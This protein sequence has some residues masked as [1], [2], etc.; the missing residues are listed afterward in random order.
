MF[1]NNLS[2]S[3]LI[4]AQLGVEPVLARPSGL[5]SAMVE[6]EGQHVRLARPQLQFWSG[7]ESRQGEA[8]VIDVYCL[9]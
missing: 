4:N 1:I 7:Q 8:S 9:N 2:Y 5:R 6:G 3:K